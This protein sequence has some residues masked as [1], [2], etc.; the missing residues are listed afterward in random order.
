MLDFLSGLNQDQIWGFVLVV[1]GMVV[2]IWGVRHL[3][4]AN[5]ASQRTWIIRVGTAI[6]NRAIGGTLVLIGL[7][8]LL[9][10]SQLIMAARTIG[11]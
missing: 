11:L 2:F 10:G 7:I 1:V 5:D 3:W 8:C 6:W 9:A 4:G